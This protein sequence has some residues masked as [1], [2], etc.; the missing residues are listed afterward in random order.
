V[1]CVC[2]TNRECVPGVGTKGR[3]SHHNGMAFLGDPATCVNGVLDCWPDGLWYDFSLESWTVTYNT[4]GF[5][6]DY[7]LPR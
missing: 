6:K 1:F 2:L 4:F 7:V 3:K 5:A